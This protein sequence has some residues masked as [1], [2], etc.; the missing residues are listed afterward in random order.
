MLLLLLDVDTVAEGLRLV[1]RLHFQ[2]E[3]T[4][5]MALTS[6]HRHSLVGVVLDGDGAAPLE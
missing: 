2:E 4:G 1:R 3:L 5:L 6:R